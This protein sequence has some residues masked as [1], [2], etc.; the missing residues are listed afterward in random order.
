MNRNT[1][2]SDK[3]NVYANGYWRKNKVQSV[4]CVVYLLPYRRTL[5]SLLRARNWVKKMNGEQWV[6]YPYYKTFIPPQHIF[7]KAFK[8]VVGISRSSCM[9][10]VVT[11]TFFCTL[12]LKKDSL[13]Q[14][15]PVSDLQK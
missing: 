2:T 6:L 11:W 10:L 12:N 9:N 8:G 3:S 5:S 4:L 7:D 14:Y 15:W 1:L 13:E